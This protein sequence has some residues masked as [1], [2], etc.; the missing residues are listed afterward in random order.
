LEDG[1]LWT[2][3]DW[4]ENNGDLN[5]KLVEKAFAVSE[6]GRFGKIR[7]RQVGSNHSGNYVLTLQAFELFGSLALVQ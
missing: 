6:H 2:E 1:V 4:Q 7:L 5:S 3:L